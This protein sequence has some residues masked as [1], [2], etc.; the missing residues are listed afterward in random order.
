MR[1]KLAFAVCLLTVLASG[2]VSVADI[3]APRD[4]SRSEAGKGRFAAYLGGDI[5]LMAES[6]NITAGSCTYRQAIDNPHIS[7][8]APRATSIHGYWKRISGTCPS[9]SNVDTYLSAYWC[10]GF[11][12][13]WITVAS[14]SG[15]V[16]AGG[17]AG[18]RITARRTCSSAS[19][20]VGWRGFVDVDL[21]GVNDPAGYTYSN[22]ANLTCVP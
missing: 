1:I 9:T 12:C 14:N 22:H 4:T 21:N 2:S 19:R 7:S 16:T 10:D 3:P 13:R 15:N 5:S 18:R 17:G 20:V 8:T 11:G 6:G